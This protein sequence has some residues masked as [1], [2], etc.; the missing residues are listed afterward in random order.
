M[1]KTKVPINS[2]RRR[3]LAQAL[4]VVSLAVGLWAP[5]PALAAEIIHIVQPGENLFRIGLYYGIDWRTLMAANGLYS[6][7]IYV[8]Q[9]LVIPGTTADAGPVVEATE[10]A[11]PPAPA[12]ASTGDVYIVQRGDTLWMI[13]Q[14]YQTTVAALMLANGLSNPNLI[15]AGQAL[16]VGGPAPD[17]GKVLNVSGRG[18]AL[19]LDCESRSAVD[20]AAYFGFAIDELEFFSKLPVSDDPDTGFVGDVY[21]SRGQ[22]PPAAYGVHAGPVADVL[23]AYGVPARAAAGLTWEALRAEI[24]ANRPAIVW[25]VGAVDAGTAVAY[26]AASNGHTTY[27]AAYEHTVMVIGYGLDTVMIR[28]GGQTYSRTLAQFLASWSVLG[29]MAIVGP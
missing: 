20:W 11:P 7:N 9:A 1:S 19:P 15:F 28:D 26:T 5:R 18:Q 10:A 22:I 27:V 4:V 25:V 14:R 23:R 6:T 17:R 21:G 29:N 16:A 13:A 2:V 24:D 12:P 8:G 3:T